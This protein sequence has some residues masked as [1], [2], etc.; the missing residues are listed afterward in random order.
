MNFSFEQL[1]KLIEISI[2]LVSIILVI[3]GWIIPYKQSQL[4]ANEHRVFDKRMQSAKWEKEHIDNQISTFYG[5]IAELLR[6]QALRKELIRIQL[7]RDSVFQSDKPM[8]SDLSEND[9]Q[10]WMHFMNMYSIPILTKILE[11]IQI[12]LHLVYN[13]ENPDCFRKFME[14][15]IGLELLDNQKR[16]GVHNFYEYHYVY[17]YPN[18]FNLYIENTLSILLRRQKEIIE[19]CIKE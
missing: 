14:Y 13:S 12:N 2:A 18:S 9:Q 6:E 15:V 19:I 3:F 17:N 1:T 7:N 5:P 11:I 10:I 16:S 8:M 4:S